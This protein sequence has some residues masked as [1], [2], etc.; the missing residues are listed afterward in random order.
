MSLVTISVSIGQLFALVVGY[1]VLDNFTE[2]NWRLMTLI[3][4]I[5]GLIGWLL[6]FIYLDDSARYLMVS[7][8]YEKSFEIIEKMNKIN[9]C[10]KFQN[11][12]SNVKEGMI[13]WSKAIGKQFNSQNKASVAALFKGDLQTITPIIWVNM[14]SLSLIYYGIIILL[15]SLLDSIS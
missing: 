14:F 2:G 1:F 6:A 3:T 5:P 8:E 4:G 11:L 15:P 13:N 12:T 7:G 10:W 9:G